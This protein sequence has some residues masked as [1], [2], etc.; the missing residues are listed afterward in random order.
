MVEAGLHGFS[1]NIEASQ[2]MIGP[3]STI[4]FLPAKARFTR[5]WFEAAVTA[6]V[7][8]TGGHGRVRS[9]IILGL[10]PLEASLAGVRW[11][12]ERGVDPVL[13]PFRPARTTEL[14]DRAAP[15]G[16]DLRAALAEARSIVAE[17]PGVEL[18]PRCVPCQ[19]NTLSFP[20]DVTDE[21]SSRPTPR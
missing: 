10:E 21:R 2:E 3:Q 14:A 16:D 4:R 18:G 9:L 1:L 17:F 15:S 8:A 13:S 6:A 7:E 11:L 19:H 12:A 20:W 5:P